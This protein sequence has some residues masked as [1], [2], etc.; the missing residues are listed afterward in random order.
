MLFLSFTLFLS[1]SLPFLS[2][3]SLPPSLPL[4]S[5]SSQAILLH[6]PCQQRQRQR[7]IGAAVRQ[8]KFW[9]KEDGHGVRVPVCNYLILGLS[10]L[11]LLFL[12]SFS[13]FGSFY[14]YASH[15]ISPDT[16]VDSMPPVLT[17]LI[18]ALIQN[19]HLPKRYVVTGLSTENDPEHLLKFWRFFVS[20]FG[21]LIFCFRFSDGSSGKFSR[22]LV[23][24]CSLMI[25]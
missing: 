16:P 7:S 8:V 9:K 1:F 17:A 15:E 19:K 3:S 13:S 22:F 12:F 21:F 4:F 11:S 6:R 10:L 25:D 18:D 14:N 5:L 23:L 24:S 2:S 20:V